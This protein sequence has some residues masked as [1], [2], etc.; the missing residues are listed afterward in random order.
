MGVMWLQEGCVTYMIVS[1]LCAVRKFATKLR[2]ST[3][4]NAQF[5]GEF[6]CAL[7]VT[8]SFFFRTCLL[9]SASCSVRIVIFGRV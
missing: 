7:C 3:Q 5:G 9:K 2:V 8:H 1:F 4:R 6:F